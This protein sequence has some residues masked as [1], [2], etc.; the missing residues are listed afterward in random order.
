MSWIAMTDL[1]SPV[2]NMRGIGESE[3]NVDAPAAFRPDE[4]L[5]RGTFLVEF[6]TPGGVG[7]VQPVLSYRRH[8]NWLRELY[9]NIDAGGALR[10][11]V[12]QG[13]LQVSAAIDLP[14]PER[15]SRLRVSYTWDAPGR[16]GRLTVE[17]LDN[18]KLFQKV[19]ANPV[20]LPA[21]DAR[22]IIRNGRRS[23]IAPA[24]RFLAFSNE[25]E[26]VGFGLGVL[27]G[28]RVATPEGEVPIERLRLGDAVM[29]RRSGP[30]PVRWIGKRTV[31]AH[32]SFQPVRM[33]KPYFGLSRDV[34]VAPEQLVRNPIPD[35]EYLLGKEDFQIAAKHLVD[36]K[37]ARR[38]TGN[39]LATYYQ[40][41]LDE[42]DCV[43]HSGIWAESLFVGLIA[44]R[45][46]LVRSTALADMP[47]SAIPMHRTPRPNRLSEC[48]ARSLASVL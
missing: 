27:A 23:Q 43:F 20:P 45:A 42:H 14:V 12:R 7:T 36:G 48:E 2:F 41:V 15:E 9:M 13:E 21:E 30:R 35:A 37:R 40:I 16:V 17:M 5:P 47:I 22:V 10:M 31:P 25:V 46:D 32:G 29:T 38:E 1:A 19:V 11:R 24:V 33:R 34:L 28:T 18:G 8:N 39:R 6:S 3:Q 4:I 44:R 26:P